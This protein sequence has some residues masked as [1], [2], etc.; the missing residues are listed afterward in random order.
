MRRALVGVLL[1][2]SLAYAEEAEP[3]AEPPAEPAE[4]V[5]DAEVLTEKNFDAFI[6]NNE[7]VLVKFY[8]PWCGHCKKMAPDFEKAAATLKT[9]GIRLGKV[10]ATI[11]KELGKSYG[12]EGYPTLMVFRNA[13]RSPYSGP[14]DAAGLVNHMLKLAE[15]AAKK[16]D[17]LKDWEKF[18]SKMDTTILGFYKTADGPNTFVETAEKLRDIFSLGYTSNAELFKKYD[19]KEGDIIIFYPAVFHSKFE[20]KSRTFNKAGATVEEMIQFLKDHSTPLVGKLTKDNHATRYTKLPLVVVY[21]NADFSAQYREGSEYWRQKVLHIANKYQKDKYN[22]AVADEEEMATELAQV[23]LGDSGLE[24]NVIAFGYDGKKYPM[25]PEAFDGELDEN[26]ENFMKKLS[27]GQIK[28]YVKSA[29]IPK[30]DK[31]D[32]KTLVGANFNKVI[33]GTKDALIEFYAPWCGHCKNFEPK[34]DELAKALKKTE[35]NLVLTKMDATANDPPAEYKV[36]GF[37]T[38]MFLPAGEKTPIQYRGNR[39]LED[40]KKFMAK[41]A[42]KSFKKT[43]L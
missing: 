22:F 23:G 35:P 2:L 7:M 27:Q 24:H 12:V 5:G 8:A 36:E 39:D 28:P 4:P 21:Y 43:E 33:D 15:P 37:P 19:A 20:P 10:D 1:L 29:P 11:E 41:H 9:K 18:V 34:Y 16:I 17:S 26:L 42:K 31:G 32:V 25:D 30:N 13:K 6:T 38:I 14:R 3:T 40:L